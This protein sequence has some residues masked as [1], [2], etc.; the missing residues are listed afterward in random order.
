VTSSG[1]RLRLAFVSDA[2]YP[3]NKGGKETRL[4]EVTTRLAAQG[5]DVHIYTMQWWEGGRHTRLAGVEYHAICRLHPLY[6]G[7]RRSTLQAL[8]F[9]LATLRMLV[10][11]FDVLDVDHMPFFPL[12]SARLVCALRRK[13]LL[14]TWHEVWGRDYWSAYLGRTGL[15]GYATERLAFRMPHAIVSNSDHTTARLREHACR[16]RVVTVPLG[17]DVDHIA[18]VA[19][20]TAPSDVI[21]AGRLLRNKNVTTLVHA[22]ALLVPDHPSLRCVIVGEGPEREALE[23]QVADSGLAAH[24]VFSDFL[25]DHDDLLGLFKASRVFALPSVREGFGV[26]VLEA[27]ACGLPVVTVDHPDNAA[28]ELVVE[29]RNGLVVSPDPVALAAGIARLLRAPSAVAPSPDWLREFDWGRVAAGVGAVLQ[30]TATRQVMSGSR[31]SMSWSPRAAAARRAM[32]RASR[33]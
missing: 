25:D 3:F 5:A 7:E 32:M 28:R 14:G 1:R 17:V 29:G 16:T 18:G 24:V 15:F 33:T 4:Y 30:E 31:P 2:V 8:L 13:P 9:G 23:R 12:F 27:N 11:P 22:V 19:R 21:F 26:V 20:A 6:S 10:E